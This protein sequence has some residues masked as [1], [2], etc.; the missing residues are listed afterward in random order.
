MSTL[1]PD[2]AAELGERIRTA[3]TRRNATQALCAQEM[4]VSIKAWCNWEWGRN[5]PS[6]RYHGRLKRVL[7]APE[8]FDG[9]FDD[10]PVAVAS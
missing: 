4:R 3:R 5:I 10:E 8:L 6:P 1:P 2:P 7:G 9:L